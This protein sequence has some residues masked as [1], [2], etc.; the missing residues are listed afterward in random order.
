LS[1]RLEVRDLELSLSD[2][3]RGI[4]SGTSERGVARPNWLAG[5]DN[6]YGRPYRA[7]RVRPG[8]RDISTATLSDLPHSLMGYYSSGGNRLFTGAANKIYEAQSAA[9]ALQ[10]LPSG[11]PASS[12]IW[13][14]TNLDGVLVAT[15][16]TGSLTPLMY[17]GAWKELKLPKPSSGPTYGANSAGGSVDARTNGPWYRVRWRHA[18]GSSLSGPVTEAPDVIAGT[19]T[20]NISAN[21]NPASPRSDYVGWTLERTKANGTIAGPFWFVADGTAGTYAD[22]ASDASLGYLADEGIH[23]EPP[24]MDG[25]TAFAG[26]LWGWAGSNLYASQAIGDLEGTG[27]ANFDADLIFPVAKD[28]GDSIQVCVVVLDELLILKKRSVHVMSGVDPDSFVLT[29]VVYADPARGSEAGCAG[30]RAACVIGGKAYFW[31]DSGG[32]FVYSRG[33][34][35]PFGWIEVGRYLDDANA[36]AFDNL[37]LINHQGNYLLAFYPRASS[38]VADEQIVYDAR[39]KQFW[40]WKGWAARDAI[41]LKGGLFSSATMV[42]ADPVV[43]GSGYHLWATFDG[44]KDR[45]ASDGTGGTAIA[46]SEEWPWVD[47]GYPD[48]WKDLDRIAIAADGDQPPV[49]VS[50]ETDPPGG[51]TAVSMPTASGIG[52]DW[53]E[54]AASNPNDLEWDVGDWA[55]VS[56]TGSA[57]GVRG[58]TIGRRFKLTL[59]ST[60]SGDYRPTGIELVAALLPDKEY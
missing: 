39:L 56:P 27:I 7:K 23:G 13:S 30:P 10:T 16:R 57:S 47:F 31:G 42:I 43:R 33:T 58:G 52:N 48:E 25:I 50:I 12:D 8:S 36:S 54:D 4:L 14:H 6:L 32:M 22:A 29:S 60:P 35:A 11:H 24:H 2:C 28:D 55:S 17:D 49:T 19:Q 46:V 9:Y 38:S 15:Q 45:R 21:L 20:V 26:R 53:A 44:L 40:H 1:P 51:E 59:F 34:V 5:A 37:V 3:S 18:K 41:E